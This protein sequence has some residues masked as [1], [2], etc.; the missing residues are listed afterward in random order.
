MSEFQGETKLSI[1]VAAR[2]DDHGKGFLE[3][4]SLFFKMLSY[5]ASQYQFPIEII[6]VEWNPLPDYPSLY[7]SISWP[8]SKRFVSVRIITVSQEIHS[9]FKHSDT[10]QFFQFIAKNVGIRRARSPF[11]LATNVDILFSDE[12]FRFL[13]LNSLKDD[14]FYRIDRS[15]LGN[16]IPDNLKLEEILQYCRE[17]ILQIFTREGVYLS[18]QLPMIRLYLWEKCPIVGKAFSFL[19]FLFGT[20]KKPHWIKEKDKAALIENIK[21]VNK[22]Q[23]IRNAIQH[24]ITPTIPW[25]HMGASGDFTLMAK[26]KWFALKGY[27]E[28]ETWPINIDSLSCIQAHFLDMKEKVLLSPF[29]LYH[30]HHEYGW[31]PEAEWNGYLSDLE[32]QTGIKAVRNDQ[33]ELL[34]CEMRQT[35]KIL[36]FNSHSWGLWAY[37]L[38][39]VLFKI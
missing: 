18:D 35:K 13:A 5:Q 32:S 17:N 8:E 33:I 23:L 20:R 3:R 39:E 38:D 9:Q 4:I 25:L 22:V 37:D 28:I 16:A 21:S 15:D 29:Q 14:T 10:I 2:N 24:I 11:I 19:S 31:S 36:R 27:P 6:L 7:E 12:L 34:S 26:K 30:Q 1:V